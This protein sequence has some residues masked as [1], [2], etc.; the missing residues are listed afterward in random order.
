MTEQIRDLVDGSPLPNE[1][2]R[3]A[4]AYQMSA[5]DRGKHDVGPLQ[6]SAHDPGNNAA[7]LNRADRR[8]ML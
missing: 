5:D 1:L 7:S 3:Q 6:C 8:T 4:M 2:R